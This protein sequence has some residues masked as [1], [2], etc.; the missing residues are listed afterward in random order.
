MA[1]LSS[2]RL[3][4]AEV[5]TIN[6]NSVTGHPEPHRLDGI[7]DKGPWNAGKKLAEWEDLYSF[8]RPHGG[9]GGQTPYERLKQKKK[10]LTT[11]V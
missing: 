2:L 11:P 9:L 3:I 8:A 7:G 5:S 10:G 6:R 4:E 1:R